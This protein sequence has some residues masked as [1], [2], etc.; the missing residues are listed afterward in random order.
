MRRNGTIAILEDLSN[1]VV[2]SGGADYAL[3]IAE[4]F[5]VRQTTNYLGQKSQFVCQILCY[6]CPAAV[7]IGPTGC[8]SWSSLISNDSL[9][10]AC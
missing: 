2:Q 8:K 1:H 6:L 9:I 5:V 4:G 3:I 10:G 7:T